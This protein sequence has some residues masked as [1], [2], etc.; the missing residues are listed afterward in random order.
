MVHGVEC[1]D[2][3]ALLYL[4]P[5]KHLAPLTPDGPFSGPIHA[6]HIID[7]VVEVR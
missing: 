5:A 2:L 6:F 3:P 1:A 7:S 4:F